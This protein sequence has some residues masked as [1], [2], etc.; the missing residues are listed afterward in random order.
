MK[1]CWEK[2]KC[3]REPGGV[4]EARLGICPAALYALSDGFLGG[5]NGGRACIFIV[6]SLASQG[7]QH[8]CVMLQNKKSP[9]CF[10][11]DFFNSLKKKYKKT[12]NIDVFNRYIENSRTLSLD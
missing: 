6:G 7:Q 3:G 9:D 10:R 4:N 1:N 8:S 12:F 5:R 11:C 2:K